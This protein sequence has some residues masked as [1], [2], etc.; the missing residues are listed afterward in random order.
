MSLLAIVV[1]TSVGTMVVLLDANSKAQEKKELMNQLSL[2]LDAMAREIRTGSFY[3]CGTA[4]LTSNNTND[5]ATADTTFAFTESGNSLT[6][7]AGGTSRIGYR[8]QNDRLE[9]NIG[10]TGWEA[11]TP[12]TIEITDLRF[13]VTGTD[14]LTDGSS[15]TEPPIVSIVIE[16]LFLEA[17]GN[18]NQFVLQT[19]I[20]QQALD[21]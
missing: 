7:P 4:N 1:T 18:N 16:G 14:T 11:V 21:I 17:V 2:T 20:T 5:C 19:T 12:D 6:G 9:R 13:T 3:D 10:N 8:L 15:N